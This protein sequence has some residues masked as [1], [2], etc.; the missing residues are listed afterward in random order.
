MPAMDALITR[1]SF[2]ANVHN[3]AWNEFI[4]GYAAACRD[5]RLRPFSDFWPRDITSS[6]MSKRLMSVAQM[7]HIYYVS[8]TMEVLVTAASHDWPEDEA[9]RE[10][11]FPQPQGWLWIPGGITV[12]DVRGRLMVTCA[13]MWDC[14]GGGVDIHMMGDINHPTDAL[15]LKTLSMGD[16]KYS[17]SEMP[18]LTPWSHRRIEYGEPIPKALMMGKAVPPEIADQIKFSEHNGQMSWFL[19][20]GW[21]PE[22]LQPHIEM[23]PTVC[24][25]MSCLRI[26]Q[27]PLAQ[28][29]HLGMPANMRKSLQRYKV[30]MRNTLVTVIEY[31]RREGESQHDT[32]RTLSHRYFRRGHWRRQHYKDEAGEWQVKSIRIQPQIVGDA[33]LPLRLREHVNALIR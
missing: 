21:S 2:L 33:K 16:S 14:Y 12:L 17:I 26:M 29:E 28:I 9:I 19:P 5:R 6:Q 23:I 30:K 11:D 8:P 7:S 20:E 1:T 32:G 25:L 15:R 31:R 13:I 18:R 4:D 24:W 27:Q 22:D 3:P 10:D